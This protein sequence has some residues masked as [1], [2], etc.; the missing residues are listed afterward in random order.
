MFYVSEIPP[1]II[2]SS[3][4]DKQIYNSKIMLFLFV[5]PNENQ[6]NRF[7]FPS[8]KIRAEEYFWHEDKIYTHFLCVSFF[9]L[10]NVILRSCSSYVYKY[11]VEKSTGVML[12]FGKCYFYFYRKRD[13]IESEI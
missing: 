13:F 10:S 7:D 12:I 2:L 4:R 3:C 8:E 9:L 6:L 11:I 1:I 5:F